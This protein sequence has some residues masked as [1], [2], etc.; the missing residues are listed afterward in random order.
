VSDRWVRVAFTLVALV[1]L[2]LVARTVDW[3]QALHALSRLGARAPLVVMPAFFVV[4]CDTLGWRATFERSRR[5][6]FWALFRIRLAT[7]AVSNSLPAGPALSEGLKVVILQRRHGVQLT[8]ATANVVIAKFALA[9]SQGFF[10]IVGLALAVPTL[11]ENSHAIMGRDGLE[12][13]AFG[14]AFAFLTAMSCALWAVARGRLLGRLGVQLGRFGG[15]RARQWLAR[16]SPKL[17]QLDHALGVVAR[18]PTAQTRSAVLLFFVGWVCMAC[19]N[20]FILWLLS[21]GISVAQAISMEAVVSVVR[22]LFFF[23]PSA[24]G[25]QEA[26]YYLVLRAYGIDNP[27]ASAAAFMITKRAKE[28]LWMGVGY[29]SL[30]SMHVRVKNAYETSESAGA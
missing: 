22:I 15:A 19:E 14:V 10:L 8:D 30:W 27:E 3:P 28:L 2:L 29:A 4:S 13:A 24:L 11:R 7:D 18:L 6:P 17:H 1:A 23:V 16:F 12:W 21:T 9:I 5:L 20:F 25:A 26:S